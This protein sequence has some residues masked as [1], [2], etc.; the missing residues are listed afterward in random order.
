[1]TLSGRVK[2][3]KRVLGGA[4]GECDLTGEGVYVFLGK[5]RKP[6]IALDR[7]NLLKPT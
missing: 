3:S 1:M 2:F 7:A 4:G 6:K 5:K